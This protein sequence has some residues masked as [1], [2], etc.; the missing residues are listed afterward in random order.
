MESK[1]DVESLKEQASVYSAKGMELGKEYGA[2]ALVILK[3]KGEEAK[4]ASVKAWAELKQAG[5]LDHAMG[6][7]LAVVR[8]LQEFKL[9]PTEYYVAE[10]KKI[11]SCMPSSPETGFVLTNSAAFYCDVV[12]AAFALLTS[13]FFWALLGLLMGYSVAYSLYF[14][15]VMSK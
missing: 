14:F 4:L 11:A 7:N 6:F 1:F 15:V 3:E 5:M 8:P 9:E 10:A 2:K 12:G 13:R